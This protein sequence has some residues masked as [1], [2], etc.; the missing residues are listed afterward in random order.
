MWLLLL[1]A[2]VAA[3]QEAQVQTLAGQNV[4]GQITALDAETLVLRA[5]DGEQKLATKDVLG[6]TFPAPEAAAVGPPAA[7]VTLIDDSV[8]LAKSY[9]QS[10]G[11]AKVDL[12]GGGSVQLT[13]R[14]IDRVQFREHAD[15]LAQQ[16]GDIVK[17]ERSADALVVR[18]ND[19]LDFLSGVIRSVGDDVVEFE[20]DG[21]PLRVKRT[22]VD[23]LLYHDPRRKELTD[24]ACTVRDAAGSLFQVASL[25]LTDGKIEISTPAGLEM[26]RPLEE[27]GRIDFS[28]G[29]LQYLGDLKP[30]SSLWTPYLGD[31]KE[32]TAVRAFFQPHVDRALDGG[33]LRLGGKEYAK[34]ISLHSRTELSYRLPAKVRLFQAVAG[35]DDRLRPAVTCT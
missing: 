13:M 10:D 7:W 28:N 19:A 5:A 8:L 22:K 12:L 34:G 18:K 26:V 21:D 15:A 29:N 32:S 11:R 4:A 31:A 35:I 33:P 16:W 23:G 9:T 14:M 30:E 25:K 1:T 2:I 3:P 27:L 17:T 6:V 24:A 20:L